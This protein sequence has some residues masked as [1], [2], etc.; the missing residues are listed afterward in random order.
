[1]RP[2]ATTQGLFTQKNPKDPKNPNKI[3]RIQGIFFKDLKSV[4]IIWEWTTPRFQRLNPF[5]FI[6]SSYTQKNPEK[7]QKNPKNSKKLKNPKKSEKSEK[8][9]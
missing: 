7:I 3:Q 4:Y 1:M 9:Q 2:S 8:I 6:K 5:L